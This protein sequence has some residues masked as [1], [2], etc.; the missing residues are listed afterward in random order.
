M[1]VTRLQK[2]RIIADVVEVPGDDS[3]EKSIITNCAEVISVKSQI[4]DDYN[5]H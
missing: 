5:N 4:L 1:S 2:A 3:N